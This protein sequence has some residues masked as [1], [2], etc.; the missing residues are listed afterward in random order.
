MDFE[1]PFLSRILAAQVPELKARDA[2]HSMAK[3]SNRGRRP[4]KVKVTGR[5]KGPL[6]SETPDETTFALEDEG[7]T[8]NVKV[9]SL[10]GAAL[11]AGQRVVVEGRLLLTATHASLQAVLKGHIVPASPL[12]RQAVHEKKSPRLRLADF[13][14]VHE[15]G[16]VILGSERAIHD[17]DDELKKQACYPGPFRREIVRMTESG[18]VLAA[19]YRYADVAQALLFVRRG[20]EGHEFRF[21]SD[22]LFM[23]DLLATDLSIYLGL[24]HADDRTALDSLVD[25]TFPSASAAGAA[26]A[27]ALLAPRVTPPVS[28][29]TPV[30]PDAIETS[31]APVK[32]ELYLSNTMIWAVALL[33]G[34]IVLIVGLR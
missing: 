7:A 13:L 22:P 12:R 19:A 34:A 1:L 16:L 17:V 6:R 23:E 15:S 21:W 20:G 24:G 31:P 27:Q 2:L 5:I 4:R 26:L 32:E 11:A 29:P 33:L 18:D 3:A 25:E 14:Q 28:E 8:L 10:D 30:I 9:P